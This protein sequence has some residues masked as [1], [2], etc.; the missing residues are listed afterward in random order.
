[1]EPVLLPCSFVRFSRFYIIRLLAFAFNAFLSS[2][3]NYPSH[4]FYCSHPLPSSLHAPPLRLHTHAHTHTHKHTHA[5][6]PPPSCLLYV[7][8]VTPPPSYG[9]TNTA[10]CPCKRP[11][12]S[13]RLLT[14]APLYSSCW[15]TLSMTRRRQDST[16]AF[17]GERDVVCKETKR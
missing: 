5:R 13:S 4:P 16:L 1:M 9:T 3:S 12:E 17:W 8:W 15:P 11:A 7:L 6:F 10:F 14:L 2:F